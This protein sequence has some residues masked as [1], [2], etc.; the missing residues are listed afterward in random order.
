MHKEC[1]PQKGWEVLESL[2]DIIANYNA[3]LAGGTALAL[4]LGHRISV[5]LDLFTT[6][7]FRVEHVI[8]NI[9]KTGLPFRIIS[10]GEGTLVADVDDIRVSLLEYEY[11]FREKALSWRSIKIARVSD[12]AAMKVVAICQRGSKRDFADLY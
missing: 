5:D 4:Q 9:R 10:E 6:A 12:I 3:V 11:P 7:K 2:K 1:F 8:S